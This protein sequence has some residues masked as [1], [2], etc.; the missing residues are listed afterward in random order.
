MLLSLVATVCD[1]GD[2]IRTLLD[3]MAQQNRPPDEIVITDGGSK[4][5][6]VAILKEYQSRLPLKI[7]EAPDTNI[8]EGR[9]VAIKAAS[10]DI[11]AVTDAGVRLSP[12]WLEE[13]VKPF[14]NPQV[15]AVAGSH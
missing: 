12:N 4:D 11:I 10:G 6:T 5:N 7:L 2:S 14:E 8:A 3:S 15:E 13:L 1:E 9:N